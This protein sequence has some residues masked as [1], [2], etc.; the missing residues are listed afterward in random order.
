MRAFTLDSTDAETAYFLGSACRRSKF[1]EEAVRYFKKAIELR[2][3]DPE[4]LKDIY[5]HLAELYKV[6]HRFD[7]AFEAYDMALE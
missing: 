6:L 1:E 4:K 7:A 3:P 2:Q 5:I